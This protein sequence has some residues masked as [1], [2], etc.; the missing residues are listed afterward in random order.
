MIKRLFS[1]PLRDPLRFI[2]SVC[3]LAQL[4]LSYSHYLCISKRTKMVNVAF[5][6]QTKG[7][8]QLL[9]IDFTGLKIH[10]EGAQKIKKHGTNGKRRV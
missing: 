8:I 2:D 7:T 3:K 1:M 6:T 4:L 5:K 9:I 10:D